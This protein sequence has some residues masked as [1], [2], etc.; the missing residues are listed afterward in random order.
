MVVV[1][2]HIDDALMKLPREDLELAGKPRRAW[3]LVNVRH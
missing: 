3:P 1:D 2:F